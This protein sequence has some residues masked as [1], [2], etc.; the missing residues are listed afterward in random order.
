[1]PI[2]DHPLH[3]PCEPG[4]DAKAIQLA[5]PWWAQS[6]EAGAH[7][8]S[9]QH[10]STA[11]H[12]PCVPAH[13][14]LPCPA[15]VKP[16]DRSLHSQEWSSSCTG[17]QTG[18]SGRWEFACSFHTHYH[19]NS[20]PPPYNFQYFSKWVLR[21]FSPFSG[22]LHIVV[23]N[24]ETSSNEEALFT[25]IL[26][27]WLLFIFLWNSREK[28]LLRFLQKNPHEAVDRGGREGTAD[29]FYCFY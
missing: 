22:C 24:H 5:E 17:P 2:G 15:G 11:P 27:Y 7:H 19:A 13:S 10:C 25:K 28:A 21:A 23:A 18:V 9:A 6:S 8:S 29:V 1:M 4:A 14:T 3:S 12:S 16:L 20:L 26:I